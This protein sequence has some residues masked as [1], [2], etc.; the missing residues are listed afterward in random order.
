MTGGGQKVWAKE[1][2][3]EP[4]HAL[5]KAHP[6]GLRCQTD[7]RSFSVMVTPS[8]IPADGMWAMTA[9]KLEDGIQPAIV[10]W[11]ARLKCTRRA[12][13]SRDPTVEREW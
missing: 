7:E 3:K 11:Q 8:F 9:R 13:I 10:P 1:K 4:V 5:Y 12:K 6:A 2:A